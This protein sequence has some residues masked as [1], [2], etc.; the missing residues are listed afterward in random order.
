MTAFPKMLSYPSKDVGDDC[1]LWYP[2]VCPDHCQRSLS[3]FYF[4]LS[5]IWSVCVPQDQEE[6][7]VFRV[8]V[9]SRSSPHKVE[10]VSGLVT[11]SHVDM[12]KVSQGKQKGVSQGSPEHNFSSVILFRHQ[13]RQQLLIEADTNDPDVVMI[14]HPPWQF[15]EVSQKTLLT[16]KNLKKPQKEVQR[17]DPPPRMDNHNIYQL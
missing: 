7:G 2:K 16:G 14:T 8:R 11:R 12:P 17:R 3:W 5:E 9:T 1:H 15:S 13:K 4:L 10:R 6:A